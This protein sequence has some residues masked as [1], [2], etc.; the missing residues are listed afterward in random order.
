MPFYATRE[1]KRSLYAAY[2]LRIYVT[3][4]NMG[5]AVSLPVICRQF[6]AL[7]WYAVIL[8]IGSTAS[9]VISAFTGKAVAIFG[10]KNAALF[11]TAGTAVLSVFCAL[12]RSLPMFIAG[13][14]FMYLFSGAAGTMP[15]N[16]LVD[17]T[18]PGER[19]KFMSFYS[20]MNNMGNL[21][22][23][24]LGGLVTDL[25]GFHFTP[26]YP[27]PLAAAALYLV[28]TCYREPDVQR[29]SIRT[30]D[31][32]GSALL[33]GGIGSLLVFLNLGG[34][35]YPWTSPV[36]I[37]LAMMF[38]MCLILFILQERH[39]RNPVVP[40]R[41][42]RI[43]SF[44]M[45][46]I[47]IPLI[48]PQMQLSNQFTLLLVQAGMGRSAASSGTYAIPKTAGIILM[49]FLFGRWI[50]YHH[51]YQ[52]RFILMS[53]AIIGTMELC[54]GLAAGLA[55][56]PVLMYLFEFVLGIGESMY[57][58]TLYPLYQRNLRPDEMPTGI[59]IQFLLA[60]LSTSLTSTVYGII[61]SAS[62]N[63]IMKAYPV[64]CFTTLIPTGIYM[65]VAFFGL[66][67]PAR[68]QDDLKIWRPHGYDAV[69]R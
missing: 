54:M 6:N 59:S 61:L 3:L 42:F 51:R 12:S 69:S 2:M 25:L 41:M 35:S 56:F 7:E 66:R 23:P 45:A 29:E 17:S 62:G 49:S 32:G 47:L 28:I 52:K 16:I 65:L 11:F 63:D 13:Y 37:G 39:S 27:L 22:G 64:M 34:D 33:I 31:Y 68:D 50:S 18:D 60:L 5:F 19:P 1:G 48:L 14:F 15:V 38:I 8:V 36:I 43:P 46:N 58:M 26:F 67:S 9:T 30:L 24:V 20:I 57:Y 21:I 44:T 4:T 10:R 53:G 55:F 40:L